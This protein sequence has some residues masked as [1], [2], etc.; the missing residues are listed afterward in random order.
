MIR[1]YYTARRRYEI[2]P[3]RHAAFPGANTFTVI[4][5]KNGTGKS[6]L[7]QGV[8]SEILRDRVDPDVFDRE[9]RGGRLHAAHRRVNSDSQPRKVICVSTSPFDK[10]PLLRRNARSD[11]YVYLGLRGLP[12]QNLSTAYMSRI[13]ASLIRTVSHSSGRARSLADVLRYLG[14]DG[15]IYCTFYIGVPARISEAI[16][17]SAPISET[18]EKAVVMPT[19][20][21][22]NTIRQLREAPTKDV[23]EAM[24]IVERFK[25][26]N[27]KPRVDLTIDRHGVRNDQIDIQDMLLLVQ[28]GVARLR[29]VSLRKSNV[30]EDVFRISEASS[31]EQSV[32]MGLLGIASEIEDGS[33]ICIDEPEVCLHP[34]WQERYVHLL[35]ETFSSRK[36]CQ[37][38]IATHSPQVVAEL[39]QANCFVMNMADGIA[40]GTESLSR[41]S[42]DFQLARVFDA[43]GHNNEFL[44]RTA[45]NLFSRITSKKRLDDVELSDFEL[46]K[47]VVGKLRD[48][49]PLRDLIAAI[50]EM[51]KTYGR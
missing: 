40:V 30:E 16:F 18:L 44:N 26:E 35:L 10:F 23:R 47:G 17:S 24:R 34:E 41:R 25:R 7:L 37:F 38:I 31:G 28:T 19:F 49:D 15:T 43:P 45:L 6:R 13:I 29:D 21:L 22:S 1:S 39:P 36:E 20:E 46:L 32:I 4:V 5:G 12:S 2:V 3:S 48:G 33:L 11:D 27:R 42:I 51:R 9:E 50:S 14:Y 8:V